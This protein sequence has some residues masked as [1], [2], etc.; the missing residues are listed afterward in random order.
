MPS[1][2]VGE[3]VR[4]ILQERYYAIPKARI[5]RERMNQDDAG[6]TAP[7]RQPICQPRSVTDLDDLCSFN[8]FLFV[9]CF[10]YWRR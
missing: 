8:H 5:H 10:Q 1:A 3:N 2:I 7:I 4:V 9:P 6:F